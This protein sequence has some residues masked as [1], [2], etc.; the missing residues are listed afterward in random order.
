MKISPT[1]LEIRTNWVRKELKVEDPFKWMDLKIDK[2]VDLR[3]KKGIGASMTY[4]VYIDFLA[5]LNGERPN[6]ST[7]IDDQQRLAES[8]EFVFDCNSGDHEPK[9]FEVSSEVS[10]ML[11]NTAFDKGDPEFLK[12]PFDTTILRTPANMFEAEH[13]RYDEIYC[14]EMPPY[15]GVERIITFWFGCFNKNIDSIVFD[16]LSIPVDNQ[17]NIFEIA[18]KQIEVYSAV[19]GWSDK[20]WNKPIEELRKR[21]ATFAINTILYLNSDNV[22]NTVVRIEGTRTPSFLGKPT[23]TKYGTSQ[24]LLKK[25]TSTSMVDDNVSHK[26]TNPKWIVRGHFHTYLTGIGRTEKVQKFIAPYYKG[27]D[28]DNPNIKPSNSIYDL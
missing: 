20:S 19:R 4:P 28:K 3:I 8:M 15:P 1:I 23:S 13:I 9:I 11:D 2:Y 24:I 21:V 22:K 26:K 10:W 27:S 5:L 16:Y 25:R 14:L 17:N 6:Y 12:L 18:K 7:D